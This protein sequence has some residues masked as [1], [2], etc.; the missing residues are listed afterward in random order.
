VKLFLLSMLLLGSAF[1]ATPPSGPPLNIY[2]PGSFTG[3]MPFLADGIFK[4]AQAFANST[5]QKG[6]I[7]GRPVNVIAQDDRAD[8]I[9]AEANARIALADPNH[10]VSVGHPFSSF[11]YPIGKLYIKAGKLLLT[12]YAT[13]P[14]VSNLG[15]T[16]FQ[17]CFNDEFQGKVL[18]K[19]A[20]VRMKA[21][22]IFILR[23]ESDSYSQGLAQLFYENVLALKHSS[24]KWKNIEIEQFRYIYDKLAT[25][26]MADRIRAFKP[27]LIFVPEL[28]IRAAEILRKLSDNELGHLPL[29]GADGWGSEEGTLDI[30]FSGAKANPSGN[31]YYT[32]HW[33]PDIQN[34]TNQKIKRL[35]RKQTGTTP[36]GPGVLSM[37][38]LLNLEQVIQKNHTVDNL[39]LSEFLRKSAFAGATGPV[40]YLP[41]GRTE[42]HM[43]L[44][45]L[46][47]NGLVMDSLVKPD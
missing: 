47:P 13:N 1:G 22:R 11:A 37:E 4:S 31:Y 29:L 35:L 40:R 32:Y 25:G 44:L 39:R 17:L 27:D 34:A 33:H 18:A 20:V 21:K 15:K 19:V 41:D 24:P 5:N 42:R 30:F 43:V 2:V 23:N 36:Y 38:G 28:K 14:N 16:V 8:L 3:F 9:L 6:G 46:T 26:T 45:R 7:L 10:L 12:P